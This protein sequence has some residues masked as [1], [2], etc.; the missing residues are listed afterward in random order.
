[1]LALLE[2]DGDYAKAVDFLTTTEE[3]LTVPAERDKVRV[4]REM[5]EAMLPFLTAM[6]QALPELQKKKKNV[7]FR[8]KDGKT[9]V[10]LKG[11]K[12]GKLEV[13]N[14]K[15]QASLITWE[16][17]QYKSVLQT[18]RE[19]RKV[20][21][22][23]FDPADKIFAEPLLIFGRLQGAMS[24]AEEEKVLSKMSDDFK[25]QWLLWSEFLPPGA[26]NS[27]AVDDDDADVFNDDM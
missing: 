20:T 1:M 2:K 5:M 12:A 9:R 16:H 22:K 11:F 8:L 25:S 10:R 6:E 17:I 15:R 19:C 7:I 26:V 4:R 23:E 21:P 14:E 13:E 18:A 27:E 3:V 24:V